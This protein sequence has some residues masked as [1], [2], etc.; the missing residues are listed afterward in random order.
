MLVLK[1]AAGI[2]VAVVVLIVAAA[3]LV[4]ADTTSDDAPPAEAVAG[5]GVTW[6]WVNFPKCSYS[7]GQWWAIRG[8]ADAACTNGLYAEVNLLDKAG[9]VVGYAN[10]SLGNLAAGRE[11][12]MVFDSFEAGAVSAEVSEVNCY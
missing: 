12:V 11:A 1:I 8:E 10:D 2:V 4:S 9:T 6:T 3:A 5:A 7:T